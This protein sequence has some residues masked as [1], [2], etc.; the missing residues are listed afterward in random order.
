[1]ATVKQVL[2]K[3]D[4]LTTQEA[5]EEIE[6][7]KDELRNLLNEGGNLEDAYQLIENAFGLEPDYLDDFLYELV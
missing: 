7:F 6:D 4:G 1:M 2:M 3:R 5:D